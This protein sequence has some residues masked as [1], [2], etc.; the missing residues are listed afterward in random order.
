MKAVADASVGHGKG[1]D[2][3][4]HCETR[5][6][7]SRGVT[8]YSPAFYGYSTIHCAYLEGLLRLN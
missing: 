5:A 6:G 8:V 7:A 4:Q 1:L 3:S 2:T